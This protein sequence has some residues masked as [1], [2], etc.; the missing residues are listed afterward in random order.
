MSRLAQDDLQPRDDRKQVGE[1]EVSKMRDAEELAL[2]RPLAV[3]ED[4]A[5]PVAELLHDNAG[6]HPLWRS[7]SGKGPSRA[8]GREQL[9]TQLADRGARGAGQKLGVLDQLVA[10]DFADVAQGFGQ[11]QHDRSSRRPGRLAL[12]S[13]LLLLAQVEIVVR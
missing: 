10:P 3:G 13:V 12:V 2:H 4:R 6:V 8:A 5:E 7:D 1:I 9:E 11:T